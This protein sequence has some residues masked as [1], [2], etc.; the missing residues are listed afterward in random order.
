M[1]QCDSGNRFYGCKITKN[2]AAGLR[3]NVDEALE[4]VETWRMSGLTLAEAVEITVAKW[5]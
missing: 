3:R 2:Q 4:S 1:E 5:S